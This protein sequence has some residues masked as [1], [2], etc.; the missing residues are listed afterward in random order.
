MRATVL[1]LCVALALANNPGVVGNMKMTFIEAIKNSQFSSVMSQFTNLPI[2]SQ[3]AGPLSLGGTMTISN[4]DANNVQISPNPSAN[5]L[6]LTISN[7]NVDLNLNWKF[8][9]SPLPSVSGSASASG[10]ISSITMELIFQTQEKNGVTVPKVA[11]QNVAINLD[12]GAFHL[13]IG[14]GIISKISGAITSL[15]NSQIMGEVQS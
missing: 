5:A 10:P 11:V 6:D 3:S 8:H 13:S 4:S 1:A 14:S 7:T 15:F 12:K 2:P 9:E